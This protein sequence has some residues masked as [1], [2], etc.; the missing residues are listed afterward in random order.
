MGVLISRRGKAGGLLLH[1]PGL[2]RS[3]RRCDSRVLFM[4]R[5]LLFAQSAEQLP[6]PPRDRSPHAAP[7]PTPAPPSAAR[8]GVL[9]RKHGPCAEGLVCAPMPGG[10]CASSCGVTGSGVRRRLRRDRRGGELCLRSA[11]RR[12]AD[13]RT[14]EGYVVRSAVARVPVAEHRGDRAEAVRGQRAARDA[15]F[16][17]ERAR[18]RHGV[19]GHLSVRAERGARPPTAASSRCTARAASRSTATRSGRRASTARAAH[20]RRAVQIGSRESLRS[21]ARARS[22]RHRCTR[23]GSASTRRSEQRDRLRDLDAIAA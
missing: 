6:T 5:G 20:D 17:D 19:A 11:A 12:D 13:C 14:D 4:R 7:D 18:G 2:V 9:A 3:L 10:Y 16:G 15:A 8:R 21:V 23:C 1:G 22:Q